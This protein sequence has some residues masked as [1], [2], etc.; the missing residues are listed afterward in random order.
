MIKH[1]YLYF[2]AALLLCLSACADQPT[3]P[4]KDTTP[5]LAD[6][7]KAETLRAWQ[8]Y[9]DYAWPH[10]NLLPLSKG[11][12]D[13]YEKPLGISPIDAYSTLKVMGADEKAEQILRYVVDS[14]DF[15]VDMNVKVF[16]VNI[17]V[18]GGL[19]AMYEWSG[20]PAVLAKA[21]DFGKR[22]MPAFDTPTGMPTY[23][24]NLQTGAISGDVIC[25]AE[26]GSYLI[27]FGM[28]SY[29]TEDPSFYQA[30]K[31]SSLAIHAR[32]SALGLLGRN[33]DVQTGEWTVRLARIGCYV[34]SHY[35]YL[36][37]AWELFG[38]TEIKAA[39]EEEIAAVMKYYPERIDDATWYGELNMDTGE[40]VSSEIMLWDA[41][42]PAIL[43]MS[44]KLEEAKLA[45]N[46]WHQYWT[47]FQAVGFGYNYSADTL[48][49]PYWQL[50]P[51]IIESNFYL[52]EATGDSMYY[53]RAETYYADM[54]SRCRTDVAY[55]HLKDIRTGEQDDEMA[56]FFIAETMKYFYLTFGGNPDVTS[57]T[58]VFNT[59]A[60]PFA[61]ASVDKAFA[62]TRLGF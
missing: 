15:N 62:K 22:L 41:Y 32:R 2:I 60:H 51:E 36:Y 29:Y 54:K 5:S 40:K 20:D 37:K 7:V 24:V 31:K 25:V 52:W 27:E 6:D 17:R 35:E 57:Q 18:L 56:T 26:A 50:N 58:H 47:K 39:W 21:E 3:A 23:S 8:A 12:R 11:Y 10:D 48:T 55:A 59:E 33:I 44:G 4:A 13:W 16:E 61:K 28:L 34:D 43:T 9:L 14:S 1:I 19:L 30:A 45:Q 46:A 53:K 49:N 42:F 38:D